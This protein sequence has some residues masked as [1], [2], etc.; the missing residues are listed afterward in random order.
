V[1]DPRALD[2]GKYT[3]VGAGGEPVARDLRGLDAVEHWLTSDER[4]EPG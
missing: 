2:Y 4:P 3:L 1:R